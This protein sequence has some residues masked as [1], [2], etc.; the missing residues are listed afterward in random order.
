MEMTTTTAT[1]PRARAADVR[2]TVSRVLAP[3]HPAGRGSTLSAPMLA[4][5][6]ANWI[7]NGAGFVPADDATGVVR[8]T[9]ERPPA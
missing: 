4:A 8:S 3:T 6:T 1:M 2:L 7:K 9:P 5:A